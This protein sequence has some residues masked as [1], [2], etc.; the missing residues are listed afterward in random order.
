MRLSLQCRMPKFM[1]TKICP[2]CGVEKP[3]A[4][5][6]KKGDSISHKCKPC[7]LADSKKRQHLYI[8]KYAERQNEW[9]K[10]RY[11]EDPEYRQKI[12]DQKKAAYELRREELN[13]KRRDRWASDPNDPA[14]KYYRR[15][16]V[17]D[18]TPPWVDLKEIGEIHAKCPKGHE[19]DHIVPLRG[20]V[21]G[22]PVSGLHVPWNLQYLTV[23]ANR[24]KKNKITDA[25]L[26]GY[27][28]Q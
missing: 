17:K 10:N 4:D 28:K 2:A 22:R 12:A 24:K 25:D 7:S 5:F 21:D 6:Y 23:Q 1:H 11:Q 8:G 16:D 20:L 15:K 13:Q 18:K 3:R 26:S 19:V 27:W 9:R 14:R